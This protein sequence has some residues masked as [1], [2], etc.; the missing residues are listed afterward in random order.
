MKAARPITAAVATLAL[1]F[2]PAV[3]T[4]ALPPA[5]GPLAAEISLDDGTCEALA[6]GGSC[7]YDALDFD[8]GARVT[9]TVP[10]GVDTVTAI[11]FGAGGGEAERTSSGPGAGGLVVGS[12]AVP[13]G[14]TQLWLWLGQ[15]P[16]GTDGGL[17]WSNGGHGQRTDDGSGG[18]GGGGSTAVGIAGAGQPLI[19]AG[20]GGGAGSGAPT[21]EGSTSIGGAGGAGGL[22]A[23]DGQMTNNNIETNGSGGPGGNQSG[24]DGENGRPDDNPLYTAGGGGGGAGWNG[25]GAGNGGV[26]Q[27]VCSRTC[28]FFFGVGGGGGGGSSW[29]DPDAVGGTLYTTGLNAPGRII[30]IGGAATIDQYYCDGEE[31]QNIQTMDVPDTVGQYFVVVQGGGGGQG[32]NHSSGQGTG[33]IVS[34]MLNVYGIETLGYSAGCS[35]NSGGYGVWNGGAHGT[36]S[37]DSGLDGGV[38]GALSGLWNGTDLY[39]PLVIAGGGGGSGGDADCIPFTHVCAYWG[40]TG[41]S[42]Y[43][44]DGTAYPYD[45][46]DGNTPFFDAASGGCGGCNTADGQP[47]P[48]GGP[49]HHIGTT[50]AGGGGGGGSGFPQGGLGGETDTGGSSGGGGGAGASFYGPRLTNASTGYAADRGQ[51]GSVTLVA[52][53]QQLTTLRIEKTV[54]GPASSYGVGPY[55]A[56][57][58]CSVDGFTVIDTEVTF[59]P[60]NP[61]EVSKVPAHADC[62]VTETGTGYATIAPPAQ[63]V[64]VA[65]G[66]STVTFDNVYDVTSVTLTLKS[67]IEKMDAAAPA[68]ASL[69]I[70]DT[71]VIL[72]CILGKETVVPPNPPVD[73]T[74]VEFD[75]SQ[76]WDEDGTTVTVPGIPVNA[77]CG[78]SVSGG[79]IWPDTTYT[80]NGSSSTG[81][82]YTFTVAEDASQ[83]EVE[84][85]NGYPTST[86]TVN[87]GSAGTGTH[88]PEP[89]PVALACTYNGNAITLPSE[90]ASFS[91]SISEPYTVPNLPVGITCETTETDR[92]I[93]VGTTYTPSRTMTIGASGTEQ[94]ITNIFDASSLL[95][96][97]ETAG[98]GSSWANVAF[99][100][101]LEC[102]DGGE[103]VVFLP[104]SF[105]PQGG[106][107]LF[108][109]DNF[110]AGTVC[111][112]TQTSAGGATSTSYSSSEDPTP[113][114]DPVSVT[115][116]DGATASISVVNT[117]DAAPLAIRKEVVGDGASFANVPY[118][119]VVDECT[120]NDIHADAQPGHES[121]Q[122]QLPAA[123]GVQVVGSIVVG[124]QCDVR[125][126]ASGGAT[127]T[128]YSALNTAGTPFDGG[129]RV[130]IDET[131]GPNP[132]TAVIR[133]QFDLAALGVDKT[134]AGPAA[135]AANTGYAAEV[136]CTF[137]G[138]PVTTL[139]EDGVAHLQFEAD[140]T[141]I[142][143]HGSDA[144]Q[145]LPVGAECTTVETADGGATSVSVSPDGAVALPSEGASVTITNTFEAGS[146]VVSKQLGGNAAEAHADQQF[147]FDVSCTFNGSFLG[148]PPSDPTRSSS[149]FLSGGQSRTFDD[150]PVGAVC[151][152][153]ESLSDATDVLPAATQTGTVTTEGASV[154][155]TNVFDVVPLTVRIV[156]TGDGAQLYGEPRTFRP[157]VSCWVDDDRSRSQPLPNHGRFVLTAAEDFE[158]TIEAPANSYC[159]IEPGPPGTMATSLT[160]SAPI[161]TRL[162]D[163]NV[164]EITADY[165]LAQFTVST[166][167]HGTDAATALF[168]YTTECLW[169]D[170][171]DT[172]EALPTTNP[173]DALFHQGDG[174]SRTITAL[175]GA[176][177]AV[178]ETD[179]HD[180]LRVDVT[181]GTNVWIHGLLAAAALDH[182]EVRTATFENWLAGSLPVT[183][184]EWRLGGAIALVLLLAGGAALAG[185]HVR[186]RVSAR[187]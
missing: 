103:V 14:G 106:H 69:P 8:P 85:V 56:S 128:T 139:G 149:F 65:S 157:V 93:A 172:P 57:V 141:L 59:S 160:P 89:F 156:L 79:T 108:D 140:G 75:I 17:G 71:Y 22:P 167:A 178:T 120:F 137:N 113:S 131:V 119:A 40:G 170:G 150:L 68:P 34:G 98:A 143:N 37:S 146:F 186:R 64:H 28:R 134:L 95:V 159:I 151:R 9:V 83:N 26:S 81:A 162:G 53:P 118:E 132:S 31:S 171:S 144:L 73:D 42:G 55:R 6:S 39:S 126:T 67:V 127:T 161:V 84:I 155:F 36:A 18:G 45:G 94:T 124:A 76:S 80:H 66:G 148:N 35:G 70:D 52:I 44:V 32:S 136:T 51:D 54:S 133:N 82:L 135:W 121:V 179:T 96:T 163:L 116:L 165:E 175:S 117:F 123:G 181:A 15:Q 110:D 24:H 153:Q 63:T 10:A 168:A 158:Q 90:L 72:S 152:A 104:I 5:A 145:S 125:E 38:G 97:F 173:A 111:T 23:Q 87:K 29:A 43:G 62:T 41:G 78:V 16:D 101:H 114:P 105:I 122:V 19:V 86:L 169:Q 21:E 25:G 46:G 7:T 147:H 177:C 166:I 182:A 3:A 130:T 115:L 27:Q 12:F 107:Q 74:Y 102:T 48:S 30:L 61:G 183:G 77:T 11:V 174:H 112:V 176:E 58:T 185:A 2:A 129:I 180:A 92:R 20:G 100:A 49:G 187:A 13:S 142:P 164:L 91:I 4:H 1:V 88:D 33:A 60:S 50:G 47:N 99:D 154:T 184:A 109:G 138:L